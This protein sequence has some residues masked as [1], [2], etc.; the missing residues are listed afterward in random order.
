MSIIDD[1]R[2]S[3]EHDCRDHEMTVLLDKKKFKYFEFK[4]T[5]CNLYRFNISVQPET[6][7]I[8]SSSGVY[9]FRGV[10]DVLRVNVN[11]LYH[12]YMAKR[13]ICTDR[14]M[15]VKQFDLE[16]YQEG[17]L[18]SIEE[19]DWIYKAPRKEV[20][21]FIRS[22]SDYFCDIDEIGVRSAVSDYK[23]LDFSFGDDGGTSQTYSHAYLW[24]YYAVMHSMHAYNSYKK[25]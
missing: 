25:K 22:L 19:M 3:F 15:P 23:L 21:R 6:F 14:H 11:G 16:G 9:V 5:E 1:A 12:D 18:L 20:I 2:L 24:C 10:Y 13:C 17:L 7:M 8:N 4:N